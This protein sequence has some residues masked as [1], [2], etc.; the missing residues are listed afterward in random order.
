MG[1]SITVADN[2]GEVYFNGNKVI[3]K[4][5]K[6]F[7][8]WIIYL[9]NC[10]F[11]DELVNSNLI[12]DIRL[13]KDGKSVILE[14]DRIEPIIYPFEL[15]FDALKEAAVKVLDIAEI[16]KKYNVGMKDCHS[17]NFLLHKGRMLYVDI[18]SFSIKGFNFPIQ[19]FLQSY[20]F[21]LYLWSFG[22]EYTVKYS[23]LW[24][25]IF[26]Y[27]EFYLI[28]YPFLRYLNNNKIVSKFLYYKA[29]L[30]GLNYYNKEILEEKINEKFKENRLLKNFFL[31][32]YKLSLYKP[33]SINLPDLKRKIE[34][35]E[36][37]KKTE[38]GEYYKSFHLTERFK[39]II[40]YT[41]K[42]CSEAEVAISFGGNQGFL[43]NE[44]LNQTNLKKI[45]VQDID[46][47][48]INYGY[49]KFSKRLD[50]KEIYFVQ[51]D[52]CLPITH[53]YTESVYK[54]FNADIVYAL[55]LLHHLLLKDGF[56]LE[57]LLSEFKKYTKRYIFIEFMPLGLW[58]PGVNINVPNWY[59]ENYF[60]SE[61]LKHFNL[62]KR[63][64][65]EE[66][67]ILYIGYKKDE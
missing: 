52:F 2:I 3:R 19:E 65:L 11:I 16:C 45:I 41:N 60:S 55:A 50:N 37:N 43:E 12:P 39:K 20:Y 56:S 62:L 49:K 26:P 14:M 36:L 30:D 42:Y 66:N 47:K 64:K 28:R 34:K 59:N 48:A 32:F 44:L 24:K 46:S 31:L 53:P 23:L 63:E 61:F 27:D 33:F 13:I 15:P 58:T 5:N 51:Y 4:I 22:L 67:R 17:W 57:Y 7:E 1:K 38:W 35:L 8:G 9:F 25:G 21:P 18:G 10:G 54:R 29:K 6:S 40:E